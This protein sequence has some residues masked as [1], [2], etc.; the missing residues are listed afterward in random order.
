[1]E[2]KGVSVA[3]PVMDWRSLMASLL[4]TRC[5]SVWVKVSLFL[6][7]EGPNPSP[8]LPSFLPSTLP[9]TVERTVSMLRGLWEG[10]EAQTPSLK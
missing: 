4:L 10:H 6:N 2:E 9:L 1:M 8:S 3:L 7:P 5:V